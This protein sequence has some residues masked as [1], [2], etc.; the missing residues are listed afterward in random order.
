MYKQVIIINSDI[1]LSKGKT[2]AQASHAAISAFHEADDRIIKKWKSE[3][4]K[5]VVVKASLKELTGAY[6]KC[7]N[8]RLP[9]A[10]IRDAGR[11]EIA[12]HTITALGVG[13]DDEDKINKVTGSMKLLK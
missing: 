10:I 8:L 4:Q 12:E 6:E 11:T 3:G 9:H 13:P 5:K 1:K 7:K 2:A